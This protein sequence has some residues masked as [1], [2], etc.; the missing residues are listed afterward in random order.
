LVT[1]D[2]GHLIDEW[3]E[4]GGEGVDGLGGVDD[5]G[6]EVAEPGGLGDEAVRRATQRQRGDDLSGMLAEQDRVPAGIGWDGQGE[7]LEWLAAAEVDPDDLALGLEEPSRLLG[8]L[9]H[10]GLPV[11]GEPEVRHGRSGDGPGG[12]VEAHLTDREGDRSAGLDGGLGET[13]W[14]LDGGDG[15]AG[16]IAADA[17]DQVEA[18]GREGK[19]HDDQER[20]AA[21]DQPG[22]P[23]APANTEHPTPYP[24]CSNYRPERADR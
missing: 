14:P 20:H 1:L 16:A 19:S 9:V 10:E 15:P 4:R 5:G 6:Q 18:H 12:D 21:G 17:L 13:A 23:R 8:E 3:L 24:E 7:R 22:P 2:A 11:T